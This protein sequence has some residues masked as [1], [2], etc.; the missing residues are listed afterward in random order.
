MPDHRFPPGQWIQ[1]QISPAD[2]A[3]AT[4]EWRAWWGA[5]AARHGTPLY[6]YDLMALRA[7]VTRLRRALAGSVRVYYALKA[8]GSLALVREL[9]RLG[10]GADVCSLGELEIARAAGVGAR[11]ALYTGPAKSDREIAAAVSWGVGL[12]VVE[13]V[14]EA[15]RVAATALRHGRARQCVLLRVNPGPEA[16]SSGLAPAAPNHRIGGEDPG[17]KAPS[18]RL[19]L[20]GPDCKFGVDEAGVPLAVRQ[21]MGMAGIELGGIHVCTESNVSEAEPL[22]ARAR[23]ALALAETLRHEGVDIGVVDLGGG[24]GVPAR[25]GEAEFDLDGYAAGVRELAAAHP[26]ISLI[27]EL[28]RYPVGGCGTYLVSVS[29]VK[30]ARDSSFVLVD[31]GINHLYRPRLTPREQPPTVLSSARA[32]LEPVTVAGPLLDPEDVL[33]ENVQLPRPRRGD[34][35]AIVGCGGYGFGHGLHG[36]CLHPTAAEVAWD[37]ERIHLIRERGD[38]REVTLGQRMLGEEP[39]SRMVREGIEEHTAK[40]PPPPAPTPGH[41]APRSRA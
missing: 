19:A 22:L 15:R 33:A 39:T 16:V 21:I 10:C 30:R 2:P 24:F 14:G 3:R 38:P 41:R 18:T 36:F 9:A 11:D 6:A 13:S 4:G 12:I 34:L 37:G 25:S 28:G 20:T 7:G 26:H 32:P 31:G 40:M 23:W 35:L 27:L 1:P 8:N 17:A 5:A 29:E